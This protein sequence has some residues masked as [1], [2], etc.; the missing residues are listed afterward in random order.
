MVIMLGAALA[1]PPALRAQDQLAQR[2]PPGA[3]SAPAV[4]PLEP[5]PQ[6]EPHTE[7]LDSSASQ[8]H[9]PLLEPRPLPR[10]NLS[11]VGGTVRKL[12]RVRNRMIVQPFGG[13]KPYTIY[14][15][16]RSR[17][18]Q[19]GRESTV[20]A[21]RVGERVH[22]ET[23]ALGAQVFARTIHVRGSYSVAQASGQVSAVNGAE[24]T[25][26]DRMSGSTVSFRVGPQTR[27]TAH[28]KPAALAALT[29]G[30]LIEAVIVS[31]RNAQAQS[32]D[33]RAAPGESFTFV[34]KV[35]HVDL[36]SG[37]LALDDERDGNNY[38]LVFD[39]KTQEEIARLTVGTP[40]SVTASFDG[41]G[42]DATSIRV[43]EER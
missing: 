2:Q 6:G 13:G 35:T 27:L 15:D 22:V 34:G 4:M 18:L 39:T 11:L 43:T 1:L 38:E 37:V 10:A 36:R 24:V 9:D 40:V 16:E 28:G 8:G 31:G 29:A 32:I 7:L 17:I 20:L 42:Y 41:H 21:L 30:A 19:D 26:Q 5:P 3:A 23:Q 33:I 25:M 12:D 14:F